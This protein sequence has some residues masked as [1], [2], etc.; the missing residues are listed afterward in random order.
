MFEQK[1]LQHRDCQ[2]DVLEAVVRRLNA[3]SKKATLQFSLDVGKVIVDHIYGGDLSL[4]RHRNPDKEFSFR[5]LAGHPALPLSPVALYRCVAIYEL[6]ARIGVA[7]WAHVSTSHLRLVLPLTGDEQVRMLHLAEM[8]RWSVTRLD[9][10]VATV[11]PKTLST[12]GRRRRS[13]F[14]R[15]AQ[16]LATTLDELSACL[17]TSPDAQ[18]SYPDGARE[19]LDV[20]RRAEGM[21]KTIEQFIGERAAE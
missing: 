19:A 6:C 12:G 8:Q 11:R 3:L 4:W 15:C 13:S 14:E 18:G 16:R 5:R 20:L 2:L 10:E 17:S 21:R 1:N 7:S 9:Q